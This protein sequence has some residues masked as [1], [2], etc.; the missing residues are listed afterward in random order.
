MVWVPR[1][2]NLGSIRSLVTMAASK[3]QAFYNE[4]LRVHSPT[5]ITSTRKCVYLPEIK[6]VRHLFDG[7]RQIYV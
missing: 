5:P 6:H 1:K 7:V 2:M 4:S 3:L